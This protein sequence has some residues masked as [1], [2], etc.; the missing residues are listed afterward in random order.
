[1][2]PTRAHPADDSE[3]SERQ[4]RAA[5][6]EGDARASGEKKSHLRQNSTQKIFT[7][8][9]ISCKYCMIISIDEKS[10]LEFF[11]M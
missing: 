11:S 2:K 3:R 1:L 10:D 7:P 8:F 6:F 4:A 5:G 9:D